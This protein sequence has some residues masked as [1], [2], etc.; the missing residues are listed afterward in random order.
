MPDSPETM[1]AAGGEPGRCR[2]PHPMTGIARGS[3][4]TH[5]GNGLEQT[6]CLEAVREDSTSRFH[7]TGQPS[8]KSRRNYFPTAQ[9]GSSLARPKHVRAAR[10]SRG[11]I[12][13]EFVPIERVSSAEDHVHGPA[14][15][16]EIRCRDAAEVED[17]RV[18]QDS[19]DTMAG[20]KPASRLVRMRPTCPRLR[21]A[22]ICA[23]DCRRPRSGVCSSSSRR[24]SRARFT[25]TIWRLARPSARITSHGHSR[26]QQA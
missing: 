15:R 17:A 19:E 18:G 12:G 1:R 25:C 6:S 22:P 9:Q 13:D 23:G 2:L 20:M 3:S 26:R 16:W 21:G 14:R 7:R 5:C 11:S 4:S 10:E 24:I 8:R